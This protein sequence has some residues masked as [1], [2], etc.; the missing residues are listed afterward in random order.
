VDKI[1][2]IKQQPQKAYDAAVKRLDTQIKTDRTNLE[3]A[4]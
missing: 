2:D 3:K 4:E 1:D